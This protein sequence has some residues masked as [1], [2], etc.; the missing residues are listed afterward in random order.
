MDKLTDEDWRA[1]AA[2]PKG[3]TAIE[4]LREDQYERFDAAGIVDLLTADLTPFGWGVIAAARVLV[5][6]LPTFDR[7]AYLRERW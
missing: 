2:H 5:P 6:R 7:A 3:A 4:G 1:L